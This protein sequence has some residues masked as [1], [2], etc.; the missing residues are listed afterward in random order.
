MA[1]ILLIRG[2]CIILLSLFGN[3]T[4]RHFGKAGESRAADLSSSLI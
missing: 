2:K 3:N 4:D 1:K